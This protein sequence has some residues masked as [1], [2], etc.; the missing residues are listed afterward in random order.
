MYVCFVQ[1]LRD[2]VGMRLAI[3]PLQISTKLMSLL[4]SRFVHDFLFLEAGRLSTTLATIFQVIITFTK[5]VRV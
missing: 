3:S 4:T 1:V 5:E 2:F